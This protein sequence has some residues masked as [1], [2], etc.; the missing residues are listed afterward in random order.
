VLDSEL[1]RRSDRITSERAFWLVAALALTV[2]ASP[3]ARAVTKT[4]DAGGPARGDWSSAANWNPNG[5]PG[6]TDDVL[7][8]NSSTSPL[9][10]IYL[11]ASRTINS[12][13]INLSSNQNWNLGAA[14]SATPHTLTVANGI[15]AVFSASGTGTYII[16]ATSGTNIGTGILTLATSATGFIFNDSRTNG[17][18]LRIDAIVSGASTNV[19]KTGV[20][21]VILG[22]ANTYTGTTTVGSG[23]LN[24][25]N[26]TALGTTASG[27]TVSSG[28]TLQLQGGITVGAEALA[29]TGTGTTGQNGA[30]VNV[31]GTNDYGGLVALGASSTISSDSGTL[32]LTNTGTITGATFGFTLTGSGSGSISSIIGTTSGTLTKN[33]SGTWTL[34]GAN[35]YTGSTTINAGTLTAADSS[36]SALGSTSSIVINST[37]TL[38]LGASNQINNSATMTLNGGT[39]KT[40]G[41]SERQLSGVTVTPGIGALT[42]SSNS[43]IDLGAGASILAFANS[44]AQ[45]W[46]GTLKIYNWSG[47]PAVGNGTDQLYF[48]TDSTGLTAQQLSQ[49]AF[50]SDSGTTFLGSAIFMSGLDGEVGPVPEPATW[51]AAALLAGATAWS[52]RHRF[53]PILRTRRLQHDSGVVF[54]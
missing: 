6:S 32:N 13:T 20:G 3:S 15:I 39:F 1:A 2:C 53:T 44:S 34:T 19:T 35:T 14:N 7:F 36:G 12:V 54:L 16:G 40:A 24:I 11:N 22:G 25:Q 5:L 42:L 41:F 10:D 29:I 38:L 8:D 23:V 50:Y 48:G 37:G 28:A 9:E 21:T 26:A 17:G 30:L 31:S 52:Q 46:S 18:F 4:W 27:T 33:G 45:A 51:F 47:N 43:I 49:I